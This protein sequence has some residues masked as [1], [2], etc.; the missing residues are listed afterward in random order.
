ME[1]KIPQ[2]PVKWVDEDEVGTGWVGQNSFVESHESD[3]H[4]ELV[5]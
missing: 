1:W 4:V 3:G 5:S 2:Q